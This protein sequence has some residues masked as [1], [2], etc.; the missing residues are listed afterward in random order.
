MA[1]DT[2]A[3]DA[4]KPRTDLNFDHF[5]KLLM[6]E[7]ERAEAAIAGTQSSHNDGTETEGMQ[8][9]ELSTQ[10]ENHPAD[11]ATDLQILEQ[12]LALVQNARDILVKVERALHKLDE[13]T[14]GLSDRSHKPIPKARLE[15]V[16]Y[17]VYMVEEQD[18]IEAL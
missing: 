14:Y 6:A 4:P 16:P 18:V 17:A 8:M 9:N 3:A 13:G 7:K 1:A 5:R 12:D 11:A 10:D 15:A 2:K